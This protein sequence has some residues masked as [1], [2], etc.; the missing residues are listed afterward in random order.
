VA[1]HSPLE[2]AKQSAAA[3]GG[4]GSPDSQYTDTTFRGAPAVQAD[5]SYERD[6]APTRVMRLIVRTEDN[7]MYELRVDMP[8]GTP[9]E[10]KGTALFKGAR[11][12]LVIGKS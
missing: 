9:D 11:D 10:K 6:G 12:R 7:R 8:K 2:E 5:T 1:P 3:L 4:P